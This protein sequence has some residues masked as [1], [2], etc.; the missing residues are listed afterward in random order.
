[1]KEMIALAGYCDSLASPVKCSMPMPRKDTLE[2]F[3]RR[4]NA[5]AMLC[6]AMLCNAREKMQNKAK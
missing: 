1:M 6:Y 5:E 3:I 2:G 4:E